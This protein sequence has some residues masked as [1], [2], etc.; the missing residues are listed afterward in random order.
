MVNRPIVLSLH[1]LYEMNTNRIDL[2]N[3]LMIIVS[4]VLAFILPFELFLFSYAV[5]GP[6]HYLTEINWLNEKK[7]FVSRPR[8]AWFFVA[9]AA[10]ITALVIARSVVG[11]ADQKNQG[12][13]FLFENMRQHTGFFV[14]LSLVFAAGL[15]YLKKTAHLLALFAAAILLSLVVLKYLPVYLVVAGVFI[16]TIIHVY[17]FTLL[18]MIFGSLSKTSWAGIA[19]IVL[20]LAVPFLIFAVDINA[21]AYHISEGVRKNFTTSGLQRVQEYMARL[22]GISHG[23][24]SGLL[25]AGYIKIQVFIAFSY[26]YHYLNWFT[27]TSIIGWN[28]NVS[29]TKQVVII[30][31]WLLAIALYLADYRTGLLALF[32]L[33]FLHVLLEFPLNIASVKGIWASVSG[34]RLR[35]KAG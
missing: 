13:V 20:L 29:R 35:R 16:P 4:L 3:L 32:F 19:A 12:P 24:S 28:K 7:Y 2:L 8:W 31:V 25:S 11:H 10:I 21:S 14:F 33:S 15:S 23:P 9:C 1:L 6:L 17:L 22:L 34:K 5:L 18:F 26:T 27:K 30:G